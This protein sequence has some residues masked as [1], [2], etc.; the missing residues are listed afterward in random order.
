[1]S[2]PLILAVGVIL[3][4]GILTGGLHWNKQR[5]LA[6]TIQDHILPPPSSKGLHPELGNRIAELNKRT[7]EGPNRIESLAELSSLYHANGYLS[8]AWQ[9]YRILIELDKK[10]PLW[11]YRLATIVSNFGHLD[12]SV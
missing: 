9:N 12:D 10:N 7:T 3:I 6:A 8:R 1:M 4:A 5:R 2:K 11:P